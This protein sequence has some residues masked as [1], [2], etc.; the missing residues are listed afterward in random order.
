MQQWKIRTLGKNGTE[1]MFGNAESNPTEHTV[2][3]TNRFHASN[4]IICVPQIKFK[5]L[6][7]QLSHIFDFRIFLP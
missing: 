6:L 2:K 7:K 5:Y 1:T 3:I 4:C